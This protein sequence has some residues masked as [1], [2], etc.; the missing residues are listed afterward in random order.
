[1]WVYWLICDKG[2]G[3]VVEFLGWSNDY[4][5]GGDEDVVL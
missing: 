3:K 4:C 5:G 1:M 2:D